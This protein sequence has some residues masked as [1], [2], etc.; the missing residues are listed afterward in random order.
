MIQE[1]KLD[2]EAASALIEMASNLMHDE[3][4]LLELE[5]PFTGMLFIIIIKSILQ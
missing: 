1:G 2:E 3:P 4:T 5:A